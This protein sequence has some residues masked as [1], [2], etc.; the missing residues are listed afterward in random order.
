MAKKPTFGS[1]VLFRNKKKLDRLSITKTT[2]SEAFE[3]SPDLTG[4]L[5]FTKSEANALMQFLKAEFGAGK[6]N[7]YGKI[8]VGFAATI[9]NSDRAGDYISAWCSE[10]Y[11]PKPQT[12]SEPRSQAPSQALDDEIP[13]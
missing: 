12:I 3:N 7:S 10:P 4:T 13:F 8:Q 2:G 9:R 1:G 6:E 5:E 11:T